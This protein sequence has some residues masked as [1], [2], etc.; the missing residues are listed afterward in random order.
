MCCQNNTFSQHEQDIAMTPNELRNTLVTLRERLN[1]SQATI[2]R[3]SLSSD[4]GRFVARAPINMAEQASDEQELDMNVS[5][6]NASSETLAMIDDALGHLDGG[7]FNV[8][9]DCGKE[10]GVRRLSV[11]PWAILCVQC[12]RKLEEGKS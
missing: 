7:K 3:D 12:Q 5:Q 6:L 10:I 1:N 8:C 2:K 11:Q 4:S 9:E